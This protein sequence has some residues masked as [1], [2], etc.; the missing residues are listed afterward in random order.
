MLH[1]AVKDAREAEERAKLRYL[2][3]RDDHQPSA[4]LRR[5]WALAKAKV[6][7][8]EIRHRPSQKP[9]SKDVNR[10][11]VVVDC[12]CND[13]DKGREATCSLCDGHLWY[14]FNTETG[15]SLSEMMRSAFERHG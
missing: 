6:A 15:G 13:V 9:K 3:A 12:E 4:R 1:P 2:T 14:Y 11:W 8:L 5:K 10:P 7:A